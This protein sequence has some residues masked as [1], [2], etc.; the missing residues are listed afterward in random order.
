MP[1]FLRD[2]SKVHLDNYDDD[3]NDNLTKGSKVR[4]KSLDK[5]FLIDS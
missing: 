2:L 4:R 3:L 5:E 1:Q